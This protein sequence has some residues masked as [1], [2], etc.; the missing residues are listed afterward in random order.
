MT[1]EFMQIYLKPC[2]RFKDMDYKGL[3]LIVMID[4]RI[5]TKRV[6]II[7]FRGG[8]SLNYCEYNE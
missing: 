2:N 3:V 6:D 1:F 5:T 7:K 8:F 4:M